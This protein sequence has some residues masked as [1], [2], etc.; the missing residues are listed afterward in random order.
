MTISFFDPNP[1]P[2]IW[3]KIKRINLVLIVLSLILT[4]IGFTVLYSVGEGDFYRWVFPQLIKYLLGLAL[5]FFIALIPLSYWEKTSYTLYFGSVFLLILVELI[6]VQAMGAQRWIDFGIF[7]LQPSELA[8]LTCIL[9]LARYYSDA[10]MGK[11]SQPLYLIAPVAII[12][13][14]V[15]LVLFQPDLGTSILITLGGGIVLFVSGVSIYY[16][17]GL[18][19]IAVGFVVVVMLSRGTTWQLLEDYQFS[20]IDTYLNPDLD[21]LGEGYH[22][23]QSLIAIGSGGIK[24]KGLLNGTQSQLKF[25]PEVHTDFAFTVLAEELGLVWSL[26]VLILFLIMVFVLLYYSLVNINRF[27]CLLLAGIAGIFFLYFSTNIAMVSGLLPVVGVPLPL[28]SYGGSSILTLMIALGFVQSA[29][30][31]DPKRAEK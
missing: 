8:K 25:L 31:H 22:I 6:G 18:T 23:T 17:L 30:I 7:T 4:S 13:V 28:I 14:P 5:L 2:T 9:A 24:G 1:T 27:G 21:P 29:I 10:D 11:I 15:S 12:L 3:D 26:I 19:G 16:F 20:R